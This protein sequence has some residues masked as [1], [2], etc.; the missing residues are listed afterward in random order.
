[1]LP[2]TVH[3]YFVIGK[4]LLVENPENKRVSAVWAETRKCCVGPVQELLR[5]A[6]ALVRNDA[7]VFRQAHF[8]L[9]AFF[10]NHGADNGGEPA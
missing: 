4:F 10:V 8:A 1:M 2:V 9:E 3:H 7:V 6:D 5:P